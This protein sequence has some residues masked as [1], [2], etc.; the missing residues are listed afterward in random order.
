MHGP[1]LAGTAAR[2]AVLLAFIDDQSRLLVGWR[3]VTG[4][5]V[6]RLEAA[7]RS[8]LMSPGIPEAILFDRGSAVVSSHLLRARAVLRPADPRK[9][10]AATTKGKI[11]RFFSTK[12]TQSSFFVSR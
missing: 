6:F 2:R 5:D 10:R 8:G 7:P 1:K 11:E 3:W 4:E 12:R 9:P